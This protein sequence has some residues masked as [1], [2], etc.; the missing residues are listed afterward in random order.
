L[1][2]IQIKQKYLM[3]APRKDTITTKGAKM[4]DVKS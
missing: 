4:K 2:I 1:R 3:S